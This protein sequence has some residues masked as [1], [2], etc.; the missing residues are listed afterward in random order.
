MILL[1]GLRRRVL[2]KIRGLIVFIQF[3]I[4]VAIVVFFMYLFRNHTHKV[5]K[6]WMKIQMFFLGIKLEI[7]GNL[8]ESC[9]LILINHQSMLDIIVMEHLHS[10]N[11]A[12][13]AKKEITDLF[14]LDIL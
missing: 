3:S 6:I 9:D 13:V 1:A 4:S 2:R 8:D 10:R 12:W 5:I 11:I 7:E 14:F